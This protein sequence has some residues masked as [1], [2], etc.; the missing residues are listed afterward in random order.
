MTVDIDN[1]CVGL[2]SRQEC[3]K[4]KRINW[5]L[6]RTVRKYLEK[7]IW[8]Y[9]VRILTRQRFSLKCLFC[10][11]HWF[12]CRQ[13]QPV[14]LQQKYRFHTVFNTVAPA[15]LWFD[16]IQLPTLKSGHWFRQGAN[17]PL[18]RQSRIQAEPEE[19]P[20]YTLAEHPGEKGPQNLT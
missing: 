7:L 14:S 13:K 5:L 18:C 6:R 11:T 3:G 9:W 4:H 8:K 2:Y 1:W 17:P 16:A 15:A 20:L 10:P 19:D 12:C